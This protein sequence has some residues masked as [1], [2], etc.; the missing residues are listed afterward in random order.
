VFL[1]TP[2]G[3]VVIS[4]FGQHN[5]QNLSGAMEA[6]IAAG[7]D[8]AAF[9]RAIGSFTGAQSRLQRLAEAP[10]FTAYKDFAHAPSKV[11]ATVSAVREKHPAARL[12][13]ILELHTFSSLNPAFLPQYAG[14]LAEADEAI[15]F[16]S[17]HTLAMKKLPDLSA[18]Q[19]R[20]HFA[21]PGLKVVTDPGSLRDTIESLPQGTETVMLWMSS[22]RFDGLDIADVSR[23]FAGG[24]SAL[25]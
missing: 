14:T 19:L 21:S 7:G 4:I 16:F 23:S 8:R 22:G 20:V 12:V 25:N 13:A 2:E 1:I 18:D 6:V 9:Y 5:L 11:N 3:E 10:G 15:V 24:R 17:P